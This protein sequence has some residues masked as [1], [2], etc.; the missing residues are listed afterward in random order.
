MDYGQIKMRLTRALFSPSPEVI[1]E[2]THS[3]IDEVERSGDDTTFIKLLELLMG[4][5]M[6]KAASRILVSVIFN[7]FVRESLFMLDIHEETLERIGRLL[8]SVSAGSLSNILCYWVVKRLLRDGAWM[9]ISSEKLA[10]LAP[11]L[12]IFYLSYRD[13]LAELPEKLVYFLSN[14]TGK[15]ISTPLMSTLVQKFYM[16]LFIPKYRRE[17]I[18]DIIQ[19]LIS[20]SSRIIYDSISEVALSYALTL[21]TLEDYE[22]EWNINPGESGYHSFFLDIFL[23]TANLIAPISNKKLELLLSELIEFAKTL[24]KMKIETT[25]RSLQLTRITNIYARN[26]PVYHKFSRSLQRYFC[27]PSMWLAIEILVE[28]S[29]TYESDEAM[30]ELKKLWMTLGGERADIIDTVIHVIGAFKK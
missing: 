1:L 23:K 15:Y 30:N 21:K 14:G 13:K 3:M 10:S 24:K 29:T 6:R 16:G 27:G 7:F 20:R 18:E 19:F 9:G 22:A 11:A 8:Q 12:Y 25:Y 26:P 2:T 4:V 28:R 5:D 17:I